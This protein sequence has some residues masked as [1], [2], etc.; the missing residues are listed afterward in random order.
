MH[1]RA[2]AFSVLLKE[3]KLKKA[4]V[5]VLGVVTFF[6]GT[7]NGAFLRS[8][9]AQVSLVEQ[10]QVQSGKSDNAEW[11]AEVGRA[12]I[13]SEMQNMNGNAEHNA[14]QNDVAE[15]SLDAEQTL[16]GQVQNSYKDRWQ[17]LTC[18]RWNHNATNSTIGA[19]LTRGAPILGGGMIHLEHEAEGRP[20]LSRY[21]DVE[22]WLEITDPD[23]LHNAL[24]WALYGV[25]FRPPRLNQQSYGAIPAQNIVRDPEL[26]QPSFLWTFSTADRYWQGGGSWEGGAAMFGYPGR[27]TP[28]LRARIDE[29]TL[30]LGDDA[31]LG[32][33]W[34]NSST[35]DFGIGGFDLADMGDKQRCARLARPFHEALADLPLNFSAP[36]Y[37]AFAQRFGMGALEMAFLGYHWVEYGNRREK[38]RLHTSGS[39][40]YTGQDCVNPPPQA[41]R[42]KMGFSTMLRGLGGFH[43]RSRGFITDLE[44][45]GK[46]KGLLDRL[47]TM[48]DHAL[49]MIKYD[50]AHATSV[51]TKAPT[52]PTAPTTS[53]PTPEDSKSAGEALSTNTLALALALCLVAA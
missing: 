14:L 20:S 49:E 28:E 51:P 13:E 6:G 52:A 16:L 32:P 33:Y 36:Q 35:S 15:T 9:Q 5:A 25:E 24:A 26:F 44:L 17:Q 34:V 42:Y 50:Q 7:G 2:A 45:W 37:T 23:C 46:D 4:A 11:G 30:P 12:A 43:E 27:G 40:N 22:P 19:L 10:E 47:Y 21:M 39:A 18:V 8:D 48:E 3:M 29:Q 41:L 38:V 53:S 1:Q 31:E